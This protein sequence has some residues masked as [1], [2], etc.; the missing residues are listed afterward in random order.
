M[1]MKRLIHTTV[2]ACALACAASAVSAQ[3]QSAKPPI[4]KE[5]PKGASMSSTAIGALL[6]AMVLGAAGLKSK[7]GHQD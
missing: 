4:P 6:A 5:Q 3:S 7:R 1:T 2:A